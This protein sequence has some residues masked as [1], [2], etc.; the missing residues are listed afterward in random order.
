MKCRLNRLNVKRFLI[1]PL[2]VISV[3]LICSCKKEMTENPTLFDSTVDGIAVVPVPDIDIRMAERDATV[4]GYRNT[5]AFE[6]QIVRTPDLADLPVGLDD[7][8]VGLDDL[9]VDLFAPSSTDPNFL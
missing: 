4:P 5:A 6:G 3:L 2:M 8:S 7:L 9:P 1:A